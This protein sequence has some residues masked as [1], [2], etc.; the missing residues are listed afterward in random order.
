MPKPKNL[1]KMHV[2]A[3]ASGASVI[4]NQQVVEQYI[5]KY[6]RKLLGIEM[7]I[8]GLY[9]AAMNVSKRR[10]TVFAIKSVCDFAD[11]A[12]SDDFQA[13][14]AYT[15]SQFLYKFVLSEL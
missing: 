7:E 8:Y 10:P 11:S 1:L 5:D 6:N 14:A 9:F 4:Q 13:Y 2:G 3:V 15:S 12:K